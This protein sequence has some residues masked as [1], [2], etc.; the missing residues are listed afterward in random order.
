MFVLI[1]LVA[2]HSLYGKK[3]TALY[4]IFMKRVDDSKNICFPPVKLSDMHELPFDRG[5]VGVGL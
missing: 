2:W 5:L 3:D 1:L 4:C